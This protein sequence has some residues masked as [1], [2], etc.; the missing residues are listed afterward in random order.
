MRSSALG[1]KGFRR[2]KEDIEPIFYDLPSVITL[3]HTV[4][5]FLSYF[6]SL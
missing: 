1:G 2:N 6:L 5:R 4:I 3:V